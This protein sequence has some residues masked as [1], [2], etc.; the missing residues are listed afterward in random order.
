MLLQPNFGLQVQGHSRG[1]KF[2]WIFIWTISSQLLVLF[3]TTFGTNHCWP[4]CHAKRLVSHIQYK[5]LS[6]IFNELV[7]FFCCQILLGCASYLGMSCV[8]I[9]LCSRS[10][11]HWMSNLHWIFVYLTFSVPLMSWQP[12]KVY[13]CTITHTQTTTKWVYIDSNILTYSIATHATRRGEEGHYVKITVIIRTKWQWH[14][15]M[16]KKSCIGLLIHA[17]IHTHPCILISSTS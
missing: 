9:K 15:K 16:H 5:W 1:S 7:H 8:K 6:T 12:N 3:V 13:W 14:Q 11:P 4:E 10:W 2:H 17:H